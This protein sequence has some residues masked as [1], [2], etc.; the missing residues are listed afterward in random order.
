MLGL[1]SLLTLKGQLYF[2][3]TGPQYAEVIEAENAAY[4]GQEHGQMPTLSASASNQSNAGAVPWDGLSSQHDE[5]Q[6]LP[7]HI[8]DKDLSFP[9]ESDLTSTNGLN[10]IQV[11]GN[12]TIQS[13]IASPGEGYALSRRKPSKRKKGQNAQDIPKKNLPKDRCPPTAA[14]HPAVR[15]TNSTPSSKTAAGRG[16]RPKGS[17][18]AA[19]AKINA[20]E[21]RGQGACFRCWCM[22]EKVR[23]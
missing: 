22:R 14:R 18:L 4:L 16:G 17:H 8:N 13:A 21:V 10:P 11:M 3:S 5:G 12:L 9:F 6:I 19:E 1:K 20:H 23:N 7:D 2:C 15:R